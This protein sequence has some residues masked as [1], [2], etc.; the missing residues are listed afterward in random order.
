V[1]IIEDFV[2]PVSA[3][4]I[5]DRLRRGESVEGMLAPEVEAYIRRH[6]LYGATGG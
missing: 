1:D 4:E 6:G 2:M 3:T 5:R